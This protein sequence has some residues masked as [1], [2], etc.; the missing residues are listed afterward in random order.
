MKIFPYSYFEEIIEAYK[1]GGASLNGWAN[2]R[3]KELQ[4]CL[5]SG[6][7]IQIT[8]GSEKIVIKSIEELIEWKRGKSIEEISFRNK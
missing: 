4:N 8:K 3:I 2:N 5:N 6:E 7:S 1:E